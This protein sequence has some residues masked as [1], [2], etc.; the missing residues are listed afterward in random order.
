[1]AVRAREKLGA[2]LKNLG[3]VLLVFDNPM[4]SSEPII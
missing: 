2:G 1:M 4:D 3:E